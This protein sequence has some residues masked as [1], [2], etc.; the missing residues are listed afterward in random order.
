MRLAMGEPFNIREVDNFI[1]LRR[2][3]LKNL[4]DTF[5][6]LVSV[7][8]LIGQIVIT[9]NL[10]HL[11]GQIL[12][13]RLPSYP[14]DAQIPCDGINPGCHPPFLCNEKMRFPPNREKGFLRNVFRSGSIGTLPHHH[15]LNARSEKPEEVLKSLRIAVERNPLEKIIH[16]GLMTKAG[17]RYK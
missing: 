17:C 9:C 4:P 3:N 12:K 7:Q 13:G 15:R 2:Q 5:A 6:L 16:A 10:M 8:C 11:F 14:V 1:L